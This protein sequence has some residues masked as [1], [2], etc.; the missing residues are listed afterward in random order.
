MAV[1]H[2]HPP[3]SPLPLQLISSSL[4]PQV[5]QDEASKHLS[6]ASPTSH[7]L[8]LMDQV[9]AVNTFPGYVGVNKEWAINASRATSH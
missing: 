3:S 7:S 2:T 9:E 5:G 1:C 6:A 4:E 8:W